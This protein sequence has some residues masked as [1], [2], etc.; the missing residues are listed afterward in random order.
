M[1]SFSI[2]GG[3][4]HVV[5]LPVGSDKTVAYGLTSLTPYINWMGDDGNLVEVTLPPGNWRIIG[6]L[7]EV[8]EEQIIPLVERESE[9]VYCYEQEYPEYVGDEWWYRDYQ[10]QDD[11]DYKYSH[12]TALESL[13]SA[14]KA[15]GYYLDENP[16]PEPDIS[17]YPNDDWVADY[18]NA[19]SRVLSRERCLLLMRVDG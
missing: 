18:N 14:I 16:I 13:E 1:K 7:S 17:R 10:A 6:M 15:E 11:S 8:T 19:Q 5:E 12:Y 4:G 9:P 3:N 2:L